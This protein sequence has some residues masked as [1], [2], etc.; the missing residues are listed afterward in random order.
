MELA[1]GVVEPMGYELVGCEYL[2]EGKGNAL[3]RVYIDRENG[4]DLDDCTAVSRQLSAVLDVEDPVKEAYRLEISSPGLDRPLFTREHF[5]RFTGCRARLK[6]VA[7]IEGRRNF[8]GILR[9]VEDLNVVL[10]MDGEQL[11][12]PLNQID[13]A[14][15]VPEF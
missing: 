4:I 11:A 12:L 5:E 8:E 9:G 2:G 6:M 13:T 3:L 10:E 14:R 1:R 15:L 7:K